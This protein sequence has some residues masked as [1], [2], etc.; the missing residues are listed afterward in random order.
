[1][2]QEQCSAGVKNRLFCL[3]L[4]VLL[5]CL[6]MTLSNLLLDKIVVILVAGALIKTEMYHEI[7]AISAVRCKVI[8]GPIVCKLC[9]F[10]S[11]ANYVSSLV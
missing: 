9:H 11:L 3:L 10:G 1:M 8:A 4:L 2:F 7:T 6:S 5:L